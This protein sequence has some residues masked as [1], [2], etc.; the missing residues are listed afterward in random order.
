ML[1]EAN[2]YKLRFLG[3]ALIVNMLL[4][5]AARLLSLDMALIS[6]ATVDSMFA[7]CRYAVGLVAGALA[8]AASGTEWGYRLALPGS[9]LTLVASLALTYLE[10]SRNLDSLVDLNLF[11]N[12]FTVYVL[13]LIS[14]DRKKWQKVLQTEPRALDLRVAER[15]QLFNPL[16]MG[17]HLEINEEILK[18]IDHFLEIATEYA[19]LTLSI[20][21]AEPITQPVQQVVRE[22]IQMHYKDEE[23][24]VRRYIQ[25]R[26]SQSV[27]MIVISVGAFRFLTF[28]SHRA[29]DTVPWEI[30]S[31]F[32]AFGLWKVGDILFEHSDSV[33]RLARVLIA[34]RVDIRFL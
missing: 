4:G 17:P 18:A 29:S 26:F 23:R 27:W 8:L 9:V 12:A 10:H 2:R 28:W 16:V 34:Q 13:V 20:H 19:P 3:T 15:K 1:D 11:F 33:I 5:I 30:L 32:A 21:S 6:P 31:S 25:Y 14:I 22:A 7:Y 24:K